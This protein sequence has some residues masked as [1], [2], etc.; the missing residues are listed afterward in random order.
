MVSTAMD[1][2]LVLPQHRP[3]YQAKPP[4]LSLVGLGQATD[5]IVLHYHDIFIHHIFVNLGA[6]TCLLRFA[7]FLVSIPL[8]A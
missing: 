8:F 1:S 7:G 5:S 3:N 6:K 4:S 2:A